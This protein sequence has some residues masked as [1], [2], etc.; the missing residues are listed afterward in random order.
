MIVQVCRHH[1]GL[2]RGMIAPDLGNIRKPAVADQ[3]LTLKSG[4][5][6]D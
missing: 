1:A 6:M 3:K 5:G 4:A 2:H